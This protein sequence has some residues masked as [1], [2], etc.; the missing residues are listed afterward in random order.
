M[1]CAHRKHIMIQEE[2]FKYMFHYQHISI[3]AL[4]VYFGG[5][6]QRCVTI[7]LCFSLWVS[8]ENFI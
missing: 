7:S 2:I 4:T 3:T 8:S 1:L 6:V 5:T